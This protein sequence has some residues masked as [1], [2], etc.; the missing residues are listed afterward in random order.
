MGSKLYDVLGNSYCVSYL[1]TAKM[2]AYSTPHSDWDTRRYVTVE[3][4]RIKSINNWTK[5]GFYPTTVSYLSLFYTRYE[6][7]RRLSMFYGQYAIA[8]ALGGI[9]S[10]GVFSMF[11]STGSSTAWKSWQI[12]FILEGITTVV[13]AMIGFFWLPHNAKTAW[14]LNSEERVWAE[15]RI[16][17][18]QD[19]HILRNSSISGSGEAIEEVPS[20]F[21]ESQGLLNRSHSNIDGPNPQKAVTDDRGLSSEDI[22]EAVLDWKLWYLL[23]CNILSATPATAFSVFLPLILKPLTSTPAGANLLSAPP[24]LLGATV[25][26]IFSHWSD[27]SKQRIIPILWSLGLLAVGL[28]GVVVLPSSWPGVRYIFLCILLSGTYPASPLTIAWFT[29]NF[30]EAGKRSIALGING[31]GN[32]AGVIASM[33]FHPKFGPA[34]I[35]PFFVTLILVVVAFIGYAVFR[36]LMVVINN[37]RR[38]RLNSWSEDEIE[39]ESRFGQGPVPPGGV[40]VV[41]QRVMRFLKVENREWVRD[42]FQ[43]KDR[44]GDERI[45]FQYTL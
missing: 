43:S 20:Q 4:A 26:F 10:Y 1:G 3:L 30:P 16:K 23:V 32:L 27:R 29:G 8:G 7:A 15:E 17:Q 34:Y 5:A 36:Q 25:L 11:P 33:L 13:L 38:L 44:R 24:F 21:E 19:R 9:L 14:F 18:D 37:R 39:A 28:T 31:W 45:T 41:A 40:P 12:L 22:S 42:I 2:A 6:F 35:F